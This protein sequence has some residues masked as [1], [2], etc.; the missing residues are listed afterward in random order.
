MN[1][2][3]RRTL[4]IFAVLGL[5]LLALAYVG[6]SDNPDPLGF[7]GLLGLAGLLV[8]WDVTKQDK[9]KRS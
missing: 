5:G 1:F 6:L 3:T 4:I 7:I 8:V 9:G 2:E